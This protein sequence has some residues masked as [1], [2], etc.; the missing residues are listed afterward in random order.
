MRNPKFA[1]VQLAVVGPLPEA[2]VTA[3]ALVTEAIV[4]SVGV[5]LLSRT[6]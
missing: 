2:T 4:V 6:I 5:P 1:P 3:V